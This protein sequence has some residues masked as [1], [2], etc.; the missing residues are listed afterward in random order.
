MKK[1]IISIIVGTLLLT[2]CAEM[3]QAKVDMAIGNNG[4]GLAGI[5]QEKAVVTELVAPIQLWASKAD[6]SSYIDLSWIDVEGA[7]SYRIERAEVAASPDGKFQEPAE[8]D[9]QELEKAWYSTSYRDETP[10][11]R[12]MRYYYRVCAENNRDK[13]APSPY[14][15]SEYGTLFGI[16]SSPRADLGASISD[17]TVKWGAVD[18]ATGYEIYRSTNP[19]GTG[20]VLVSTV[21]ANQHEYTNSIVKDD[22]GREFYYTVYAVNRLGTRSAASSI[23][24]GF[25]LVE[26]APP[27]PQNVQVLN[28]RGTTANSIEITWDEVT[29][30]GTDLTYYV[31]RSSSQDSALVQV[32]TIGGGATKYKDERQLKPNLYYYYQIQATAK[33]KYGQTLKS[34]FSDSGRL[35]T[36]GEPNNAAAE[37][38]IISPTQE[39]IAEKK[40]GASEITLKWLPAIGN[41]EEQKKYNYRVFGGSSSTGP[42]EELTTVEAAT[43]LGADGY[44]TA[45]VASKAFYTV[46]TI[47]PSTSVESGYSVVAA[48]TPYAPTIG[49]ASQ[50]K[51]LGGA[52]VANSS[53]VYPVQITWTKPN[54]SD[55]AGFHIYRSTSRDSGYRKITDTP[56]TE[57]TTSWN[58]ANDTAKAGKKYWYKVLS[59]NSLGQGSYYSDPVQGWGAL[60]HEQYLIEFNK[61]VMAAQKRLT[62]MHKPGSTDKLGTETK[63]AEEGTI[64]YSAQISGLGAR[65][66]MQYTNL[67][68]FY[69]DGDKANGPY[70]KLSGNSNTTA[71]MSSNG[72]MDGNI[73]CSGMYP[74]TVYYDK[75]QIKGGAAGGG[76]YGVQP[77]GFSREEVDYN[78]I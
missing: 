57:N 5:L 11:D 30:S 21:T 69:I 66:I 51:N 38:F 56:L 43:S 24:M 29:T 58:D 78:K 70:F 1:S 47:N 62:Y 67:V 13:L 12:D 35:N 34:P 7:V 31:Y 42:F 54:D 22:Q 63:N 18:Y 8:E 73:T 14:T 16:P 33:D 53:G 17:I 74:G 40:L 2:G 71:D 48:P 4:G 59:V 72:S 20:A 75:V 36:N 15:V 44:I 19:D 28:G 23:A 52:V 37:G 46:T 45:Q 10:Q 65:I 60:T 25:T 27:Q 3:F 32:A 9:F 64:Y 6:S 77:T 49:G 68:E 76:T 50:A 61:T 41:E 55:L 39:L 26:G